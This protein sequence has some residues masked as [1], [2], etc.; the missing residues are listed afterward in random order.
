MTT[1]ELELRAKNSHTGEYEVELLTPL[2][3]HAPIVESFNITYDIN[4]KETQRILDA[5]G[6]DKCTKLTAPF[7]EDPP[8]ILK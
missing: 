1:L 3:N 7:L 2:E 6:F 4:N 8:E 5:V